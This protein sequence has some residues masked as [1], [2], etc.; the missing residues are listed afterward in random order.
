MARHGKEGVLEGCW[1]LEVDGLCDTWKLK[2]NLKTVPTV[3]ARSLTVGLVI[4]ALWIS[5]FP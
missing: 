5:K 3:Q 2:A 4:D 1:Q